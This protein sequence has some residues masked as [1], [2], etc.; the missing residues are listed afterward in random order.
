MDEWE[1]RISDLEIK[2]AALQQLTVVLEK[3]P[4]PDWFI[5]EFG[6]DA[7]NGIV[8]HDPNGDLDFWR[9]LAILLRL[10]KKA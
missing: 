3:T 9:N 8:V 6:Q 10:N 7:L 1:K 4:P 5:T 2:L